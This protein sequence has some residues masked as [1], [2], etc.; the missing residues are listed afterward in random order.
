MLT[1]EEKDL[2]WQFR[3]YLS[4]QKKVRFV[5]PHSWSRSM[6]ILQSLFENWCSVLNSGISHLKILKLLQALTKFLKCVEWNEAHEA[7]QVFM[8][9]LVYDSYSGI[10]KLLQIVTFEMKKAATLRMVISSHTP[11]CESLPRKR[12]M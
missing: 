3:F 6:R 4:S 5:V 10:W 9:A 11:G 7:G 12:C 1:S 8:N 2:L